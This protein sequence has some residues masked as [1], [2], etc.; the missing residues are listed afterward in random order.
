[1]TAIDNLFFKI[2]G[3]GLNF[4]QDILETFVDRGQ[5]P[6]QGGSK[7]LAMQPPFACLALSY[8]AHRPVKQFKNVTFRESSCN[9]RMLPVVVAFPFRF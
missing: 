5:L 6:A 8:K 1:M 7:Y 9:L 4:Q 2:L 3:K